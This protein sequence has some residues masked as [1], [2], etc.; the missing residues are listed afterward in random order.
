MT[1]HVASVYFDYDKKTCGFLLAADRLGRN[2]SK[3]TMNAQQREIPSGAPLDDI[4]LEEKSFRSP[5]TIGFCSGSFPWARENYNRLFRSFDDCF[6][7]IRKKRDYS[8]HGTLM[9]AYDA[10]LSIVKRRDDMLELYGIYKR[11]TK[12]SS[13]IAVRRYMALTRDSFDE[14]QRTPYW[15]KLNIP[16][17]PRKALAP[18]KQPMENMYRMLWLNMARESTIRPTEVSRPFDFYAIDFDGIR[19]VA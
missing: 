18:G 1:L 14:L 12:G 16:K 13:P 19:K 15:E 17:N 10:T 3:K 7:D 4:I 5:N 8:T 11:R 9:T 2:V 6:E